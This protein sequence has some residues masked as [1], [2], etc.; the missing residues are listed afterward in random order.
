M[1]LGRFCSGL[2]M[3]ALFLAATVPAVS[4]ARLTTQPAPSSTEVDLGALLNSDGTFRGAPGASG[5]VDLADWTLV[6]DTTR[7]EAPR[8]A[9]AASTSTSS[10]VANTWNP[11][12]SNGAGNGALNGFVYAVA[13]S[14]TNVYVGGDWFQ[15]PGLPPA[16]NNIAQWSGNNWI[17]LSFDQ[18][19]PSPITGA[20]HAIA[21]VGF[22][23]YV[24]G[25]FQNAGGVPTAD[26]LALW[27]GGAWKA[28]GTPAS[29]TVSAIQGEVDAIVVSGSSVL[30]GGYFFHAGLA[31]SVN[32]VTMAD[33]GAMWNGSSW[34]PL[35]GGWGPMGHY[36]PL[37]ARVNSLVLD[38][39]NL[40]VGTDT[41]NI[42]GDPT[43]DYVGRFEIDNFVWHSL[44]SNLSNG[45]LNGSVRALVL[46]GATLYVGGDF[47]NADGIPNV[48]YLA[49]WDTGTG[50]WSAVGSTSPSG[51]VRSIVLS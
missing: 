19:G 22:S 24:G 16:A 42:N 6:S 18:N 40:Y 8:F 20:V 4:A 2:A 17:A 1:R 12:G 3:A 26:S 7:G 43:I 36:S 50:V 41:Q 34:L 28:V 31:G 51:I 15:A 25:S 37:N 32:N 38:G 29:P 30:V 10:L 5:S 9:P 33:M 11:L 44:D 49:K 39:L 23:V 21:L 45:S 13:V 48:N 35:G 47:T 14:G 27:E 46:A